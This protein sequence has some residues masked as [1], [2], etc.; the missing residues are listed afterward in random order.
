MTNLRE[1][2]TVVKTGNKKTMTGL[3]RGNWKE[4]QKID[5]EFYPVMCTDTAYIPVLSVN[6]SS[7]TRVLTKEFY[8]TSDK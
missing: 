6:I 4:Y 3:L 5:D 1:V 7:V 2:K 8:M